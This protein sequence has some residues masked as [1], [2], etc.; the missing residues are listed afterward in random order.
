MTCL[1]MDMLFHQPPLSTLLNLGAMTRLVMVIMS[2]S[3]NT[4]SNVVG[5]L[6]KGEME[7]SES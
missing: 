2:K 5:R 4:R 3:I 1:R 7:G 6:A